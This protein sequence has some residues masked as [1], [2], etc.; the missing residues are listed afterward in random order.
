MGYEFVREWVAPNPYDGMMSM[1]LGLA[2]VGMVAC[3]VQIV[4]NRKKA[5]K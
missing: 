1:V 5:K 4:L 2:A 3:I